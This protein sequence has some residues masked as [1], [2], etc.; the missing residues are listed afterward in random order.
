[1]G[2]FRKIGWSTVLTF[3]GIILSAIGGAL[4]AKEASKIGRETVDELRKHK[5]N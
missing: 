3:G 5:S 4:E 1:M 2:F